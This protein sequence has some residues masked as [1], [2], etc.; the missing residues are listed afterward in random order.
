MRHPFLGEDV[1]YFSVDVDHGP[2]PLAATIAHVGVD[3]LL[4]LFVLTE[5]GFSIPVRD[6]PLIQAGEPRP[7]GNYAIW[8]DYRSAPMHLEAPDLPAGGS[9]L[10]RAGAGDRGAFADAG[11]V[12]AVGAGSEPFQECRIVWHDF[13]APTRRA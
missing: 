8:P 11:A 9:R 6:V 4:T 10:S 2:G 5:D 1:Y 12:E 3:K 13:R 7:S